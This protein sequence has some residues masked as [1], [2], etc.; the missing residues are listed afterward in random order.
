M[1]VFLNMLSLK[2]FLGA[3]EVFSVNHTRSIFRLL[4]YIGIKVIMQWLLSEKE[5]QL[6][7]CPVVIGWF[8][9]FVILLY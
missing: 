1:S 2:F 4:C 7:V 9:I 8:L 6:K 3:V 5:N